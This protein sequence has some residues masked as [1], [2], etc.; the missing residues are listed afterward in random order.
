[1][2]VAIP[3]VL[4]ILPYR[5]TGHR[6]RV[7]SAFTSCSGGDGFKWKPADNL[8]CMTFSWFFLVLPGNY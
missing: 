3:V 6:G 5:H 7:V 2:F 4:Y 8:S 1:M